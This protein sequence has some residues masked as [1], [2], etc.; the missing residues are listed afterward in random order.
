MRRVLMFLF[1][2]SACPALCFAQGWHG[3]QPLRSTCDDV[4]KA[5]KVD[6]CEYPDSI[7]H[8]QDETVKV[9]FVTCPCPIT[10][11]SEYGGWNVPFGTVAGLTREPRKPLSVTEFEVTNSK[12][13][14]TSTDMMG[15]VYY[16]DHEAGVRLSTVNGTIL[17]ITYYAP[18]EK[19]EHLL[20][21]KCSTPRVVT[22]NEEN[23]SLWL[24]GYGDLDFEDEKKFLIEF[25]RKLREN[26]PNS[27]G[28][29][30]AY[31]GCRSTT[32]VTLQRA[33]RAKKYLVG[34]HGIPASRIV[35]VDAGQQESF[36]IHL[37]VRARSLPP[38]RVFPTRYPAS[39]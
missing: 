17:K 34:T 36:E 8:L 18:L 24:K 4:K 10:C 22:D 23:R 6:K 35:I 31:G 39:P 26:G 5:L 21:P 33:E 29:I 20:C 16:D 2:L 37:H 11:D 13:S 32:K 14:K 9:S 30:V 27:I 12:W 19:N 25:A 38:P 7:Y 1:V 28:Y 15:E 3:I